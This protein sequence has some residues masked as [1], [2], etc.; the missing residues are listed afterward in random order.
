METSLLYECGRNCIQDKRGSAEQQHCLPQPARL[1]E[2]RDGQYPGH[3]PRMHRRRVSQEQDEQEMTHLANQPREVVNI[4]EPPHARTEKDY[5]RNTPVD[6]VDVVVVPSRPS[7]M[8]A[9]DQQC[10]QRVFT[11]WPLRVYESAERLWP[12]KYDPHDSD[13]GADK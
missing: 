10:M 7:G 8:N 3:I 13:H 2:R 9:V 1:R 11:E 4:R 12:G 5:E 6:H